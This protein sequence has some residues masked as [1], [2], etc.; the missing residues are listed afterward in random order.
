MPYRLD[1]HIPDGK[2]YEVQELLADN[3]WRTVRS[4]ATEDS[5]HEAARHHLQA[6]HAR[7]VRVVQVLAV[8]YAPRQL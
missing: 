2:T 7:G 8:E 4:V 1:P 6:Q 3:T 5:A